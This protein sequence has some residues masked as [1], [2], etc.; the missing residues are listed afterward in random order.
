[1]A[2]KSAG[3]KIFGSESYDIGVDMG[4][5][6][7]GEDAAPNKGVSDAEDEIHSANGDEFDSEQCDSDSEQGDSDSEDGDSGLDDN[8]D[9]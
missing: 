4:K 6:T 7:V 5:A 8:D 3:R 2:S 9:E 1:M